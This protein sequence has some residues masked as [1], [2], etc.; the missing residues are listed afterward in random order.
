[1]SDWLVN[2]MDGYGFDVYFETNT[3][4]EQGAGG[5]HYFCAPTQHN[6]NARED[7]PEEYQKKTRN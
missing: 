3:G 2:I 4:N 1:M 5:C 7:Q 6:F